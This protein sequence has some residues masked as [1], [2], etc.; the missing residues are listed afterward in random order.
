MAMNMLMNRRE[1]LVGH[2]YKAT[3]Y[4]NEI[5][6]EID[7]LRQHGTSA[8]HGYIRL[9][10]GPTGVGKSALLQRYAS[11][12]PVQSTPQGTVIVRPV[13]LVDAPDKCTTKGIATQLLRGLGDSD[14]EYGT[15]EERLNRIIGHYA[16]QKVEIL[17]FD[18]S[19]QI[20]SIDGYVVGNFFKNLSNQT[21]RPVILA[22]LPSV[23]QIKGVNSQFKDRRRS[24]IR[25]SALD[26]HDR[27]DR[28]AYK[29]ILKALQDAMMF[30][31]RGFNLDDE[32]FAERLAYA[33]GGLLRRT[34]NIILEAEAVGR[35][36]GLEGL[37]LEEFAEAWQKLYYD[38]E[39]R[40]PFTH[41]LPDK[42]LPAPDDE[43]DRERARGRRKKLQ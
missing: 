26:W 3:A 27:G 37:T 18:E 33:S 2:C 8:T 43:G 20:T 30:P 41:A 4:S 12:F 32:A 36:L 22:G 5:M 24:D 28:A 21:K 23:G 6:K 29:K 40:N 42:W 9:L 31:V 11:K 15:E 17:L 1:S 38:E 16:D 25:M 13:L 10:L 14:P 35:N 34:I 39:A 7:D 19:Q